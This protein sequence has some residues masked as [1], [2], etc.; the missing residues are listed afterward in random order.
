MP[1]SA[2][3]AHFDL[4]IPSVRNDFKVLAFHG[5]EAISQLYAITVELVSEHPD[6]DLDSL[7]GQPAFLRF[8]HNGEGIHGHIED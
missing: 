4:L 7:I 5:T 3:I 6:F 8:G 1:T 2:G